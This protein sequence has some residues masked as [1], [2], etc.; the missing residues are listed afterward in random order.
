[1]HTPFWP[2][3]ELLSKPSKPHGYHAAFV[4]QTDLEVPDTEQLDRSALSSA[5]SDSGSEIQYRRFSK[6]L[7]LVVGSSIPGDCLGATPL[8]P[9]PCFGHIPSFPI[10]GH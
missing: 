6:G 5:A 1:M 8:P 10:A 3:F 7:L 2:H 4:S 9:L